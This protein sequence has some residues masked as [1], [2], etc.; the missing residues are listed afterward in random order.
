MRPLVYLLL[1][2]VCLHV[3]A[4]AQ[5]IRGRVV[6]AVTQ[7]PMAFVN[8]SVAGTRQGT[9]TD[10][11]GRFSLTPK[12]STGT[13]RV[14]FVGYK[15]ADVPFESITT[16]LRVEL[17]P[18]V[19]SLNEVVVRPGSNPAH[20][21]MAKLLANR[22]RNNPSNLP[23]FRYNAYTKLFATPASGFALR[24]D[25]AEE[26]SAV[27]YFDTTATARTVTNR[28]YFFM[29]ESYSERLFKAPGK[30]QETVL[31]NRVSGFKN[32][33]FAVLGTQFQ[34]FGF[35]D[36]TLKV[37][38][39][40]YLNPV[41]PGYA[42]SYDLEL[43]DTLFRET[44]SLFVIRFL[45]KRKTNF[46]GLSGVL[47]VSSDGYAIQS[48]VAQ[49]LDETQPFAFRLQQQ[50]KKV[51]GQWFPDQLHTDLFYQGDRLKRIDSKTRKLVANHFLLAIRTYL[52]NIDIQTPPTNRELGY[53][54]MRLLPNMNQTTATA[55]DSLRASPLTTRESQ[56]YAMYDDFRKSA[57][58]RAGRMIDVLGKVIEV[59]ILGRIS[60][61]KIDLL[62]NRL[63][64]FNGYEGTRLG[65]G[66][67]TNRKLLS[68]L[69]ADGYVGFG[70]QDKALKYG[71]GLQ[72]NLADHLGLTLRG[73]YQQDIAEPGQSLLP[74]GHNAF[75]SGQF[76]AFFAKIADSVRHTRIEL[77]GRPIRNLL[78][79]LAG[80]TEW[81]NP[82]YAY[83]FTPAPDLARPLTDSTFQTT[84]LSI[85]FRWAFREQM[86]RIK[87]Q[88][89]LTQPS[90]P[91]LAV[92]LTQGLR[93]VA[94]GQFDFTKLEARF[95]H[96]FPIRRWGRSKF[97]LI[98]GQIWADAL[99]YPYLFTGRGI[100]APVNQQ[101]RSFFNSIVYVPGYFQTVGIYEFTNDRYI[102][103]FYQHNL[104]RLLFQTH[105]KYVRPEFAL[106]GNV[107]WGRLSHPEFHQN[108]PVKSMEKG[109]FEAGLLAKRILVLNYANS[110]YTVGAGITRRL[111]AYQSSTEKENW[112]FNLTLFDTF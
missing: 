16:K 7:A 39:K 80:Q 94:G 38:D 74:T 88:D 4:T 77:S 96:S 27:T 67:Q 93:G 12:E 17:T 76:R 82:T 110:Q 48:I 106:V 63:L 11:D 72:L 35:Y 85:G 22:D 95:D 31:A 105:S 37:L 13:L 73:S 1:L 100:L 10:I 98:V 44:D 103:L 54:T 99:P 53:Q 49:S 5:I 111:G 32:P 8:I 43:V 62:T 46:E 91:V 28:P 55:W 40:D 29:S 9:T 108:V 75:S 86:T 79:V 24:S 56:T 30:S 92:Q 87:D 41:N 107:G 26:D 64:R 89:V 47:Q 20:A 61:G 68:W 34:P 112:A 70:T 90:W 104:G 69:Q 23:Q 84:Q 14:S 3:S 57:A 6:D 81:R 33:L 78:V 71:A 36:N 18:A 59:M 50:F 83:R 58:G 21:I 45:P 19:A 60:L 25:Y 102:N 65:V 42:R 51:T 2:A 109:F 52:S 101:R 15:T 97:Q 66:I